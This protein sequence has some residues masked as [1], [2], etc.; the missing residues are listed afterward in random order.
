MFIVRDK[1]NMEN[2]IKIKVP[3]GKKAVQSTDDNGNIVIKFE[4]TEPIR[5]KSWKEFCKNHSVVENEWF[6]SSNGRIMG[7]TCGPNN[8]DVGDDTNFLETKED[9]E[10][11]LA[12]IQLTRFHDEWVGDWEKPQDTDAATIFRRSDHKLAVDYQYRTSLFQFPTKEMA[13]EFF[14]CFKYLI[15]KAKKFI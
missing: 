2:E 1:N 5:S 3:Y 12:L 7:P 13:Q 15:E 14:N 11:I 9:A 10:G 6:I 4:N 8:R